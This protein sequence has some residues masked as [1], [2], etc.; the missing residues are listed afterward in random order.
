MPTR[1]KSEV[2]PSG[3]VL[4]LTVFT[5]KASE[6]NYTEALSAAQQAKVTSS[7]DAL[8][9]A[10]ATQCAE[11]SPI[12]ELQY[13]IPGAVHTFDATG[14][15]CG[16]TVLVNGD[17]KAES[18]LRDRSYGLI[19]LLSTYVPKGITFGTSNGTSTNWAGWADPVPPSPHRYQV[20]LASW[21]VPMVS[22]DF[23]EMSSA[24]EWVGLDGDGNSTVEQDGTSTQCI[25]GQGTYGAW[26]ELFGSSIDAG[27]QVNLPDFDHVHPGDHVTTMVI[28]GQGSGGPGVSLPA[29]PN[30]NYL[31]SITDSTQHWSWFAVEGPFNPHPSQTTV[32]WITEQNSCFWICQSL[33][34]Y[35]TV[36]YS[37]MLVG[38]D[39]LSFPFGTVIAPGSEPGGGELDLVAGGTLKETGSPLGAS[40]SSE[41]TTWFHR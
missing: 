2:P 5:G 32:E 29:P 4:Q 25:V 3:A 40:G 18:P 20:A 41:T 16:G 36:T 11:S 38:N 15:A 17:G 7:L 35:G 6:G 24:V 30:G 28:A 14:Y 22:C 33:A 39:A 31:F 26:W 1:P 10:P 8:P 12:Y 34:K 37:G 9:L 19:G 13:T 27:L 23:G 21:V